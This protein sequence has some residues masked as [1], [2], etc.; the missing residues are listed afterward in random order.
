V[1]KSNI[2]AVPKKQK[3][4]EL[5]LKIFLKDAQTLEPFT[6]FLNKKKKLWYYKTRGKKSTS[7]ISAW[8][9]NVIFEDYLR[10]FE[11]DQKYTSTLASKLEATLQTKLAKSLVESKIVKKKATEISGQLEILEERYALGKISEDTYE[12][13]SSKYK[14]Q[15]HELDVE[16][17]SFLCESL[18]LKKAIQKCLSLA[19]ELV[20]RWTHG[21]FNG[22]QKLQYLIFPD[23]MTYDKEKGIVQTTRING[24]FFKIPR[25]QRI[26][27]G[28]KKGNLMKDCLKSDFVNLAS[29]STN[30]LV[31]KSTDLSLIE[32]INSVLVFVTK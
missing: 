26:L 11:F 4:D 17:H 6:G 1:K 2:A 18:N 32:D 12:K 23:G 22:K 8:K 13:F 28:N 14:S 15:L 30:I 29:L 5:P 25:Q 24:I 7:C 9:M 10:F 19:S 21:D 20:T 16:S 31:Q 27:E 3:H